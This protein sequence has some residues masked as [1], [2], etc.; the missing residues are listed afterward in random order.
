MRGN[1]LSNKQAP[2]ILFDIDS[3][4]FLEPEKETILD[5]VKSVLKSAERKYIDRELNPEH[6]RMLQRIWGR[7]DICIGLFTST[8]YEDYFLN[9]LTD[10]LDAHYVPY[11]RLTHMTR[12]QVRNFPFKIYT[13]SNN[14]ELLSFL[15][16]KN[17]M[18]VERIWEVL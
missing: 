1:D 18:R 17:A 3:F 14:D 16:D 8:L 15:S 6:V 2:Y 11:T 12:E 4:L 13:F 5:K 9:E 10:K 7:H